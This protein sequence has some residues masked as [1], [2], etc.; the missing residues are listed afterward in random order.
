MEPLQILLYVFISLLSLNLLLSIQFWLNYKQKLNLL[1]IGVWLFTLINFVLQ[2][3]ALGSQL[4]TILAFSTYIFSAYCLCTILAQV[5]SIRFP[6]RKY[7][8]VFVTA[9]GTSIVLHFLSGSFTLVALPLALAMAAPQV[10]LAIN[11]LCFHPKKG[12]ELCNTF[13]FLLLLNGIHFI[14]YPFLR[15]IP[16]FAV[17]GYAIVIAFSMLFAALLPAILSKYHSEQLSSQLEQA[18]KKAEKATQEKSNFLANMSHEIR[19]PLTAIIGLNELM[20]VTPLDSAQRNYCHH[21]STSSDNLLSIINN[22]LNLS[23]LESG[24]IPVQTAEFS[25]QQLTKEVIAHYTNHQTEDTRR[26]LIRY[27]IVGD[28]PTTLISDKGKIQQIVF[29]LINNAIKYSEGTEIVLLL[30]FEDGSDGDNSCGNLTLTVSDDGVGMPEGKI[31]SIFARFE[32]GGD[33]TKGGVGLGLSIVRELVNLLGGSI[34]LAKGELDRGTIATCILPVV[35]G[36]E[37]ALVDKSAMLA[38]APNRPLVKRN[39][40]EFC[41][42]VIEDDWSN[43][44]AIT[45]MLERRNLKYVLAS[46]GSEALALYQVHAPALILIDLLLPDV[47]GLTVIK[48]I[49]DHDQ[50][51]PIVV[52]SAYSFDEDVNQALTSGANDYLRKPVQMHDVYAVIEKYGTVLSQ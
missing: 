42:L 16:D 33:R 23:Q 1:L 22:I 18:F 5:S 31:D 37:C 32:Q 45:G 12:T 19:T 50:T 25:P 51:T 15:P 34:T 6:F 41:I 29:N 4:A 48:R 14:D 8:V 36:G 13:A 20:S 30:R 44:V 9:L 47:N 28:I 38:K 40:S 11:K 26:F 10:I 2:G 43:Q 27:D 49:R 3:I 21:I 35:K 7:W 24:M 39:D 17:F 52:V 46:S